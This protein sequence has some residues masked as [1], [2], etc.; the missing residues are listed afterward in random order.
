VIDVVWLSL[1]VSLK[2]ALTMAEA[3]K[4]DPAGVLGLALLWEKL[5][6]LKHRE[7]DL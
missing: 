4:K 3:S 1:T 7:T 6:R 2:Q 5:P